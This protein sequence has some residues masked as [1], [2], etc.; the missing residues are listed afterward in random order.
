MPTINPR[1]HTVRRLALLSFVLVLVVTTLSAYMRLSAAGLGCA[2]WPNCYG[3]SL[4]ADAE[5]VVAQAGV[6]LARMLHRLAAVTVLVLALTMAAASFLGKPRLRREGWMALGL[7]VLAL[8]LAVLGRFT[9]GAKLPAVAIGNVL[10]GFAMLLLSWR[11]HQGAGPAARWS[12]AALALML[13]LLAQIALGV[14]VSAG[15]SGLSCT[16]FPGCGQEFDASLALLDPTRVP[17]F[18]PTPPIHPRGAFSH[19]LHRVLGLA[20]ALTALFVAIGSWRRGLRT[21]AM[22]LVALLTLQIALGL[23]LVFAA[24]PLLPAV[25]HNL[26]AA[27]MLAAASQHARR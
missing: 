21:P 1:Q 2:D 23:I 12:P 17:V 16:G 4:R 10:G 27:L 13:L 25:A 3:A 5:P 22:I 8:G 11:I 26:L 9:P 18:D 15:Y 14:L 20:V 19:L 6:V 24:L 7:I